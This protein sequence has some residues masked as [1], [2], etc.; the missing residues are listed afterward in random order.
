M[1]GADMRALVLALCVALSGCENDRPLSLESDPATA[2]AAKKWRRATVSMIFEK[3]HGNYSTRIRYWLK[4]TGP[5]GEHTS[6]LEELF[7]E[8]TGKGPHDLPKAEFEAAKKTKPRV[9]M[10]SDGHALAFSRDG[11]RHYRYVALDAGDRPLFCTH[12]TFEPHEDD[13]LHDAPETRDLAL[14][15]LRTKGTS[16]EKHYPASDASWSSA[17]E[18]EALGAIDYAC[19]HR[20]DDDLAAALTSAKKRFPAF[21]TT[22]VTERL[23]CAK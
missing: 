3:G 19:A 23:S 21:A 7:V 20:D 8:S 11:G 5:A 18:H 4:L 9:Q 15:I 2:P 16:G 12:V 14:A 6:T 17:F 22:V 13:A 10:A 1:L